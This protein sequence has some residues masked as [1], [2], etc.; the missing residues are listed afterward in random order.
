M[1]TSYYHG[2]APLHRGAILAQIEKPYISSTVS[3]CLPS[4]PGGSERS[5]TLS[6]CTSHCAG[7]SGPACT[8]GAHCVPNVSLRSLRRPTR[9]D[10]LELLS[11]DSDDC[12]SSRQRK[13]TQRESPVDTNSPQ[14]GKNGVIGSVSEGPIDRRVPGFCLGLDPSA[15]LLAKDH[16]P[17]T[18]VTRHA[19]ASEQSLCSPHEPGGPPACYPTGPGGHC[20]PNLSVLSLRRPTRGDLLEWLVTQERG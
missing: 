12:P 5:Q 16:T 19:A 15:G 11:L 13:S 3:N 2:T 18:P 20:I 17:C 1:N 6:S 9:S 7:Q 4:G 8:G 10:L 14:N